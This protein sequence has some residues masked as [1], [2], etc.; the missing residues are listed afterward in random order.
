MLWLALWN[1]RSATGHHPIVRTS[2]SD[3]QSLAFSLAKPISVMPRFQLGKA[4]F[5]KTYFGKAYFGK[6]YFGKAYFGK[7]L[8]EDGMTEIGFLHFVHP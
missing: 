6:A 7:A 1:R 5:G 2:L 4:Y 3:W 8:Q